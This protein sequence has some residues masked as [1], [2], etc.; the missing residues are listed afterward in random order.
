KR[1]AYQRFKVLLPVGV[2]GTGEG[3]V[4]TP[5]K[6]YSQDADLIPQHNTDEKT[7]QSRR[8]KRRRWQL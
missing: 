4:L 6:V 2:V 3:A 5:Q 8:K 7:T 1:L